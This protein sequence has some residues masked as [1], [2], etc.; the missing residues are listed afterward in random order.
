MLRKLV[1]ISNYFLILKK[2]RYARHR[3]PRILID[4]VDHGVRCRHRY[5]Q[6]AADGALVA[7]IA[8]KI[9]FLGA[10][11]NRGLQRDH[12]RHTQDRAVH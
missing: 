3:H 1:K 4:P 2:G 6:A 10:L 9:V 5:R 11:S 7:G 8:K 12:Y